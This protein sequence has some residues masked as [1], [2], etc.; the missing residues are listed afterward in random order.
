MRPCYNAIKEAGPSILV[1]AIPIKAE[2]TVEADSGTEVGT[3]TQWCQDHSLEL[4]VGKTK[5]LIVDFRG[6]RGSTHQS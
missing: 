3:L 5:E 2:T 1:V 4:N 6:L